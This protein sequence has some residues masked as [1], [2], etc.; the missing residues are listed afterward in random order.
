MYMYMCQ[1]FNISSQVWLIVNG[2]LEMV[3]K[4]PPIQYGAIE[5]FYLNLWEVNDST[6]LWHFSC[7][8]YRLVLSLLHEMG[9]SYFQIKQSTLDMTG[10][11]QMFI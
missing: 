3:P 1:L 11:F 5:C 8:R 10:L 9:Y 4:W 6:H 2:S 7:L